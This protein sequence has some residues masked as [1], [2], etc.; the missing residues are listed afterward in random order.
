[1]E[2]DPGGAGVIYVH[3]RICTVCNSRHDV[4]IVAKSPND[5]LANH[6][7]AVAGTTVTFSAS[8]LPSR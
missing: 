6:A 5:A 2:T 7:L 8:I 1:M 4:F 3:R